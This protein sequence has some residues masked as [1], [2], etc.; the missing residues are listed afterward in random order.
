MVISPEGNGHNVVHALVEHLFGCIRYRS[1]RF[2][3]GFPFSSDVAF[4]NLNLDSVII[5]YR[6]GSPTL[7]GKEYEYGRHPVRKHS[8]KLYL[9]QGCVTGSASNELGGITLE[10][11]PSVSSA[12]SCA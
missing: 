9:Q 10:D 2:T 8:R 1:G 12:T 5:K 11:T 7:E 4:L 3:V 6:A